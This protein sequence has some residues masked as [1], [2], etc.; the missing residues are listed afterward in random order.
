MTVGG[1]GDDANCIPVPADISNNLTLNIPVSVPD[2]NTHFTCLNVFVDTDASFGYSLFLNASSANLVGIPSGLITAN[3]G[4]ITSPLP[5]ANDTWGFCI[6]SDRMD[7]SGSGFP[8]GLGACGNAN[9]STTSPLPFAPVPT[10]P[11]LIRDVT[12]AVNT[13]ALQNTPIRFGARPTAA[14][15]PGVYSST[16]TITATV[17]DVPVSPPTI[18][19]VSP[20]AGPSGGGTIVTITGTGFIFN[21]TSVVSSVTIGGAACTSIN[22]A[23]DTALTCFSPA[24]TAGTQ[25]DVVVTTVGGVATLSNGFTYTQPQLP[26]QA[27]TPAECN[28][29]AVGDI[30]TLS[31]ARDNKEYRIRKMPDNKCWMMDNLAYTGDGNNT[32]GDVVPSNTAGVGG[33]REVTVSSDWN[34]P[35]G[36]NNSTRRFANNS[37]AGLTLGSGTTCTSAS[38]GTGVMASICGDQI[39]Y[40]FCAALGLDSGT[41]PTCAAVSN[42]TTGVGMSSTGTVGATGGVGGE[43]LGSGG[44]SI[45]PT[46]WRVPVG[47]VG[48]SSN[49]SDINNEWAV[50]SG[51]FLNNTLSPADTTNTAASRAPWQPTGTAATFPQWNAAFGAVSAGSVSGTAGNLGNQSTYAYWWTS[52]LNSVTAAWLTSVSSTLV[53]PGTNV[54]SKVFGFSVRCVFP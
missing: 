53:Y 51:S 3:S 14:L 9:G 19:S 30:I 22:V 17:N 40:N 37:N 2:C 21:T 13:P 23:S 7:N 42:T 4:S 50:L 29:L 20:S 44:S 39:L 18:T 36:A 54:S 15:P 27:F 41:T 46:G 43:S 45:C 34:N 38:T 6:P 12:T 47:R 26:M 10:T 52:S 11:T 28:M 1:Q 5:L 32:F 31:D 24:G 49:N 25:Q 8:T 33:L 35:A 16:V 48:S